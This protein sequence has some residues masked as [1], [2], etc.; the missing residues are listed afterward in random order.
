MPSATAKIPRLLSISKWSSFTRCL[1]DVSVAEPVTNLGPSSIFFDPLQSN[2]GSVLFFFQA[3]IGKS[4][5]FLGDEAAFMATLFSMLICSN[6][7]HFFVFFAR[8]LHLTEV[9]IS[10]IVIHRSFENL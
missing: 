10:A 6:Y 5:V 4:L 8:H 3:G 7:Y 9:R 2:T 1:D